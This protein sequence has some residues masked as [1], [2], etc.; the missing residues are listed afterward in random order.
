MTKIKKEN[1]LIEIDCD[2]ERCGKCV[3]EKSPKCTLFD[4][5]ITHVVEGDASRSGCLRHAECIKAE[6]K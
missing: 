1:E 5:L 3:Y 4:I 2:N 6:V